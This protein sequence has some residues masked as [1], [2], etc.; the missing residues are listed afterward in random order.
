MRLPLPHGRRPGMSLLEVLVAVAIFLLALGG[1]SH[2]VSSAGNRALEVNLRNQEARL[3][4]SKMAEVAS[5]I[6]PLNS[7]NDTPFDEDPDFHWSV[8]AD[9]TQIANLWTVTV[10]VTRESPGGGPPIETTLTQMIIDPSV[11]GSTQDAMPIAGS[12]QTNPNA[13]GGTT[14]SSGTGS[15]TPAAAAAPAAMTAPA[16]KATPAPAPAAPKT[17]GR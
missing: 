4:Q 2:L 15:T 9:T 6:L 5:G 12:N 13:T 8:T 10:K 14:G 3:C 11:V 1:I 16:P 7:Q 17:G